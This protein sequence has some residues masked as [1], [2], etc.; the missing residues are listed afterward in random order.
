MVSVNHKMRKEL[1]KNFLKKKNPRKYTLRL[2]PTSKRKTQKRRKR[3][4]YVS[5]V[6][7]QVTDSIE[8]PDAIKGL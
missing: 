5:W 1:S 8:L 3:K 6:R 4:N 2:W 7:T